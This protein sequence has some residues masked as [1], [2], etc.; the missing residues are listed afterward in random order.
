MFVKWIIFFNF[1][2][3]IK[4]CKNSLKL[5]FKDFIAYG[6]FPSKDFSNE[7]KTLIVRLQIDDLYFFNIAFE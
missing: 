2:W 3:I 1:K 4:K 6:Y 7:S 5:F